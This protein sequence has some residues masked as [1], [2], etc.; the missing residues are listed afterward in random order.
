MKISVIIPMYNVEKY[1][2]NC[3]DSIKKSI[4]NI[5][6]KVDIEVIVVDDGS[7]DKS[8]ILAQ[9]YCLNDSNYHYY[10]KVNGGMSD[11]RNYGLLKM[12]GD[13]ICFI[14][15]D[16]YVDEDY[17][18]EI[19]LHINENKESD[20]IIFDWVNVYNGSELVKVPGIDIESEIWT[21]APSVW[22]KVYKK[23]LFDDIT[24]VKGKW[25]EDVDVTY[26][27]IDKVVKYTHLRKPLYKYRRNRQGSIL[28][29]INPKINDIYWIVENVYDHYKDNLNAKNKEGLAYQYVK[30]LLWSNMYRQL[31]F[32]KLNL[33]GFNKKMKE[34]H[35]IVDR[36]F[37]E[38]TS[39]KLIKLNEKFFI[40]RLGTNYLDLLKSISSNVAVM[41]I[42]LLKTIIKARKIK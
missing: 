27:L 24:F 6:E 36:L 17:F 33:I 21:V 15:S 22:N 20:L 12:S 13:Y 19:I 10:S 25:Y 3:L 42:T 37:P 29:T 2:I 39:N 14:D 30:L 40:D 41:T 9:N 11:A 35:A 7:T 18:N 28:S 1:I 32:Y 16:D 5:K 8:S 23:H 4:S 38:W 31:K 34:T 26:R